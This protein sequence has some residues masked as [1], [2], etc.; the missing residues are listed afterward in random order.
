MGDGGRFEGEVGAAVVWERQFCERFRGTRDDARAFDKR[1]GLFK[2]RVGGGEFAN[3]VPNY[4]SSV[5]GCEAADRSV[6]SLLSLIG[7]AGRELNLSSAPVEDLSAR[8]PDNSN[9]GVVVHVVDPEANE[10][11]RQ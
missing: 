4:D 3:A 5:R 7:V 10:E 2:S 9:V 11:Q 8:I 1:F 6:H